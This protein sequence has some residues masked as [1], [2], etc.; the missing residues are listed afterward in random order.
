MAISRS[1]TVTSITLRIN[2]AGVLQAVE[3]VK[4]NMW[5][6]SADGETLEK[7]R[8]FTTRLRPVKF[9]AV[10]AVITPLLLAQIVA[11]L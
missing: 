5:T 7:T 3:H 6:D 9:A 11:T 1:T 4:T 10:S 8:S 2:Q